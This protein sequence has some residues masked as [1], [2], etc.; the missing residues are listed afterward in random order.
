MDFSL[1]LVIFLHVFIFIQT[2]NL[3]STQGS[4]HELQKY[5]FTACKGDSPIA[6]KAPEFTVIYIEKLIYG[7]DKNDLCNSYDPEQC[8][9]NAV[10]TCTLKSNRYFFHGLIETKFSLIILVF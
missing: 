2:D 6:L 1:L 7:I 5:N 3:E 9:T 8:H 10:I 4:L